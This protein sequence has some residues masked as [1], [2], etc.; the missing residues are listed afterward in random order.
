[1][2]KLAALLLVGVAL[3]LQTL[4]ASPPGDPPKIKI[5]AVSQV[6]DQVLETYALNAIQYEFQGS[7][8]T[9]VIDVATTLYEVC[10]YQPAVFRSR[11]SDERICNG[12]APLITHPPLLNQNNAINTDIL[13]LAVINAYLPDIRRLSC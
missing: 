7:T 2:R 11:H 6:N 4:D 8:P 3:S 5:E 10:W 12:Y 13:K 9:T 1:M